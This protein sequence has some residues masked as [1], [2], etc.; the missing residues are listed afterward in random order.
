VWT[1]DFGVV[2]ISIT[3]KNGDLS[4]CPGN[5]GEMAPQIAKKKKKVAKKGKAPP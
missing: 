1:R 2:G 4:S 5:C 3:G